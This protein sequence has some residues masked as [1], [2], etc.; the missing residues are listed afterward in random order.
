MV[1]DRQFPIYRKYSNEQRYY[2]ILSPTHLIELQ[3]LGKKLLKL[4]LEAKIYPD[5]LFI[6][7]L[8]AFAKPGIL[9][10]DELEYEQL[11]F[12]LNKT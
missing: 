2:K 8:I 6:L 4:E 10:S 1:E 12:E 7:D 9:Q 5:K 3:R 11:M